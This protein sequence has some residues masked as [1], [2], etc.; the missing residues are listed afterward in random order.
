MR[1]RPTLVSTLVSLALALAA[2]AAASSPA[3]ASETDT[4]TTVSGAPANVVDFV[5]SGDLMFLA[6][7][8]SAEVATTLWTYDG[9][10][11][12]EI[13]ESPTNVRNMVVSEGELYFLAGGDFADAELWS[14]NGAAFTH[15]EDV[16][17]PNAIVDL[18]GVGAIVGAHASAWPTDA[19][20]AVSDGTVS[21]VSGDLPFLRPLGQA[22]GRI[23]VA[24][25]DGITNGLWVLDGPGALRPV[26]GAEGPMAGFAEAGGF[27]WVS[28]GPFLYQ[29]DAG[30]TGATLIEPGV[31]RI[32][33]IMYL[34]GT[35][36]FTAGDEGAARLYSYRDGVSAPVD[37]VPSGV[38]RS[39]AIGDRIYVGS[40]DRNAGIFDGT[41]FTSLGVDA[42]YVA[43]FTEFQGSVYFHGHVFTSASDFDMNWTLYKFTPASP[44]AVPEPALA[45]TGA[46]AS[47]PLALAALLLL[48]GGAAVGIRR[49]TRAEV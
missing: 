32:G 9:A 45:A 49:R 44:A 7:S 47:A 3:A 37:V 22:G 40:Y 11:F 14:Y 39:T 29:V 28:A 48:A 36:Y 16:A 27:V 41:T 33:T 42:A 26:P 17:A 13:A 38:F 20:F 34:D 15:Y 4:V 10:S 6:A 31:G 46:D 35:L 1:R 23:Y 24:A 2:V 5:P 19:L 25:F 8:R 21:Q 18:P 43:S 30:A 12:A